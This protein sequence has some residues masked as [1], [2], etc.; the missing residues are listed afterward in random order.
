MKK[1]PWSSITRGLVRNLFIFVAC[2]ASAPT[3]VPANANTRIVEKTPNTSFCMALLFLTY[4]T[5]HGAWRRRISPSPLT[6]NSL[7]NSLGRETYEAQGRPSAGDD[8]D[9]AVSS[10]DR[11]LGLFG[12]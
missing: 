6:P 5:Y 1:L 11:A 4:E 8:G 9:R 10:S 2:G 12:S 7:S 3:A